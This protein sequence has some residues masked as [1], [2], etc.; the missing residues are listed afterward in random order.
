VFDGVDETPDPVA[1]VVG[2]SRGTD[3]VDKDDTSNEV[4][5]GVV[6]DSG[7]GG[8]GLLVVSLD[9]VKTLADTVP[10][11]VISES[12]DARVNSPDDGPSPL[13]SI[14]EGTEIMSNTGE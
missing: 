8:H 7:H 1:E 4:L 10:R 5:L 13:E 11:D 9:P 3:L 14:I 12:A 6:G 2:G